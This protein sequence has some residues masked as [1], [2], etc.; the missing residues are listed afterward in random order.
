MNATQRAALATTPLAGSHLRVLIRGLIAEYEL[1]HEFHNGG[2]KPME[3]VY[4][5]PTPSDAAFLGMEATLAGERRV[6]VVEAAKKARRTFDEAISEGDSAVLLEQVRPGLLCVD[7]G[8][9]KPGEDGE[10]VLRFATA[11]P[12]ADGSARFSLPLVERPRYGRSRYV[13][14]AEPEHDFAAEH[15]LDAEIRVTGLLADAAITCASHGA[16]FSRDG[17]AA[18]LRLAGAMLDR[19]LVLNFE[20]PGTELA[21]TRLVRDGEAAIGML[22]MGLPPGLGAELPLDVCLV[23]DGSGSM[24]GDAIA[25]SRAALIA[26]TAALDDGDRVQ[27]LR[28]GSDVLPIFRRALPVTKRVREA[29]HALVGSV[30]SDLGGTEMGAA[31][32]R[33][34]DSLEAIADPDAGRA[35]AIILVTD[36]AVYEEQIQAARERAVRLGV[37]IFVVA[38][39]SSAGTDVL[40]PLATATGAMTERAIATESVDACVMRQFRRARNGAP[41]DLHVDW[42]AGARTLPLGVL[43]PGDAFTAIA[44]LP[45]AAERVA[46]VQAGADAVPQR[47]ELPAA[48]SDAAWRAWAGQQAWQHAPAKERAALALRYGLITDDTSAI[49][50]KVRAGDD[51]AEGLPTVTPIAHMLPHGMAASADYL[52]I[53]CFLRRSADEDDA[54]PP[55]L[56]KGAL[57]KVFAAARKLAFAPR[58]TK[59]PLLV[60]ERH[61]APLAETAPAFTPERV[62]EL[63]VALRCALDALLLATPAGRWSLESLLALVDPGQRADLERYLR[64]EGVMPGTVAEA[65][66]L[67]RQ[68]A[69]EGVGSPLDDAQD[70]AL[71]LLE[72]GVDAD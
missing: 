2:D 67:L 17:D 4:S 29:L 34:L 60:R 59:A 70:V 1:R 22:A 44:F 13:D 24:S 43:Y 15:P 45:D 58:A 54:R 61:P 30:N 52:G 27:V 8:N 68:L 72:L 11:L 3:A 14:I 57:G 18:V 37:R 69:D 21:E 53:P 56:K 65:C 20:L 42:G 33:A 38:V 28:F 31:L 35:R 49:L 25:Q 36:G 46:L 48:E 39:G 9:L 26:M 47:L 66:R 71:A 40:E 41:L 23:L 63:R 50:V 5:F 51:K 10:I 64:E 62:R 7:L 6:A 55:A 16:R 12:V 32:D 19:D